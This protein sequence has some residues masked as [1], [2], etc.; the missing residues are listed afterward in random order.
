VL[1]TQAE[2]R[3]L[4]TLGGGGVLLHG[5]YHKAAA[6]VAIGAAGSTNNTGVL[7]L[8]ALSTP[9]SLIGESGVYWATSFA[10]RGYP[11]FRFDLPG[12]GDS[13]GEIP[14]DLVK[15]ADEGGWATIASSKVQELVQSR[16]L[17]G[18]VMF[19]HCSGASTAIYAA[20]KCRE[21]KGLILMDPYFNL[22][23]ALTPSLRPGLVLWARRSRT[24]ALMRAG[25]DRIRELREALRKEALPANANLNLISRLKQVVS[26]GLPILIFNAPKPPVAGGSKLRVGDFDYLAFVLSLAVRGNQFTVKTIEG[27]DHSF[28]NRAGRNAVR[29]HSE[30]WLSEYF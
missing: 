1:S 6:N 7:F 18:V 13:Y 11:S 2:T 25:Y 12:L 19:G 29:E 22:P 17:P 3:E 5:T 30:T 27:T 8:N 20:S 16:G 14:N 23:R 15:F 24:G 9:R 4:I 21:C 28:S 10:A 26:S